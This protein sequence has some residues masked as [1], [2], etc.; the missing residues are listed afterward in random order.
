MT[1]LLLTSQKSSGH[2]HLIIGANSIANAR[3][4][5]SIEV[6]AKAKVIAPADA[7]VHFA[8]RKK[9]DDG[10]IEWVQKGFEDAD[11]STLGR[12]EV[13]YVVDAVFITG[14]EG[15]AQCI[16]PRSSLDRRSL[17]QFF[18]LSHFQ[19]LQTS[20]DSR[21]CDRYAESMHFLAAFYVFRWAFAD[22]CDH[23]RQ[24]L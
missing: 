10:C 17:T 6:G 22:R 20:A 1:A 23:L 14:G 13:D 19:P 8:I 15:D 3:C 7:E 9:I 21:Q 5:R 2:V 11:L 24:R 4:A 12:E 18:R 16:R